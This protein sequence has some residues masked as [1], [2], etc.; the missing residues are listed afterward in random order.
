[1]LP[2]TVSRAPPAARESNGPIRPHLAGGRPWVYVRRVT[3][4]GACHAHTFDLPCPVGR[5]SRIHTRART[6]CPEKGCR[7]RAHPADPRPA[8]AGE[9]DPGGRALL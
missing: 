8:R 5:R 1:M 4:A 6:G 7:G 3:I 2:G 9:G